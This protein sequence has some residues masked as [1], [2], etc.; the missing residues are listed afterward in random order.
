L[1][2]FAQGADAHHHQITV[3]TLFDLLDICDRTDLRGA[4]VQDLERQRAAL[5]N[6]RRH[7]GVNADTLD[8]MLAE[9]QAASAELGSQGRIGQVLRDNEWLASLRGR[10]TV[11]GGTS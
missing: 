3:A 1:F 5:N 11:P 2:F 7:P 8:A 6:L 10:L 4:V 9:I